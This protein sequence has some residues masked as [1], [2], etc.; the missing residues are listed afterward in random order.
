MN[1]E[2]CIDV[3]WIVP[4]TGDQEVRSSMRRDQSLGH[5]LMR[6]DLSD[7]GNEL[8][9]T[10][11]R[12]ER[13]TRTRRYCSF[14][15]WIWNRVPVEDTKIDGGTWANCNLRGFSGTSGSVV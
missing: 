14:D 1:K 15:Q 2:G 7:P 9:H 3:L 6:A 5:K 10:S 8:H 4:D 13:A 12:A 11:G